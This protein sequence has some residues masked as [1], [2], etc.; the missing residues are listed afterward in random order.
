M[1]VI[2]VILGFEVDRSVRLRR[3]RGG[4]DIMKERNNDNEETEK[5]PYSSLHAKMALVEPGLFFVRTTSSRAIVL[6]EI[7]VPVLVVAACAVGDD[8]DDEQRVRKDGG[9]RTGRVFSGSYPRTCHYFHPNV[10]H[11]FCSCHCPAR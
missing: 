3:L 8:H 2:E 4:Q 1:G 10:H 7:Y 5:D 11:L 6:E 9:G